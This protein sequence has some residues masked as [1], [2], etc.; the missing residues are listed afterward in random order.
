M[1]QLVARG[2]QLGLWWPE[3]PN[4]R[5]R[6]RRPL[7]IRTRVSSAPALRRTRPTLLPVLTACGTPLPAPG[8]TDHREPEW[9]RD[10]RRET[11]NDRAIP[12]WP[13]PGDGDPKSLRSRRRARVARACRWEASAIAPLALAARRRRTRQFER[14]RRSS[15]GP[16]VSPPVKTRR[17]STRGHPGR[18]PREG[19]RRGQG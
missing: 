11:G 9:R 8:P 12:P 17:E 4:P 2:S 16:S 10:V 7:G 19:I 14:W 6:R 13:P 1:R 3:G 15:R 18:R 5:A